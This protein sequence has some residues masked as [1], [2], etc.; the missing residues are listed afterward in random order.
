MDSSGKF[1]VDILHANWKK[2]FAR[3]N[4]GLLPLPDGAEFEIFI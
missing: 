2:L 3:N 1:R 4:L